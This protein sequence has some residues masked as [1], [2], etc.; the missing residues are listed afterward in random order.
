MPPTK[1][2]ITHFANVLY[3]RQVLWLS[4]VPAT[5]KRLALSLSKMLNEG[6]KLGFDL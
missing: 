5:S 2:T 6:G 1:Q 4:L 3:W